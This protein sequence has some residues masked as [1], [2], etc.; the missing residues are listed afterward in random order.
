MAIKIAVANIV[1]F[2][3]EGT[4]RDID[5]NSEPF[6]FSLTATRLDESAMAEAQ[7]AMASSIATDGHRQ[8]VTD[9]LVSLVTNWQDVRDDA[10][11]PLPYTPEG[12][13]ALLQSRSGLN[14]MV[15]R[16][17]QSESGVHEKN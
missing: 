9:K 3:I 8:C 16:K 12:L 7:K 13:R 1:G 5:G 6:E 11:A 14:L 10:G 15:W 17:Y 4:T 2:K